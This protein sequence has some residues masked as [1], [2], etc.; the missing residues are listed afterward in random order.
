MEISL[1]DV[2]LDGGLFADSIS[3][4]GM[5]GPG[6]AAIGGP[7]EAIVSQDIET[8]GDNRRNKGEISRGQCVSITREIN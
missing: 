7:V 2:A 1:I 5:S 8:R 6:V 4:S 3:V